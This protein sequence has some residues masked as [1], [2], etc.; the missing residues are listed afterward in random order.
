M[1]NTQRRSK[2]GFTLVELIVVIA[3]IGVLA[4]IIVPTTLHFV[5]EGKTEAAR[6]ELVRVR[7]AINNGMTAAVLDDKTIDVE[8]LKNILTESSITK[9][10]NT[11]TITID[12]PVE[13]APGVTAAAGKITFDSSVNEVEDVTLTI[14]VGIKA[15]DGDFTIGPGGFD[16]D[17]DESGAGN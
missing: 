9:T 17:E 6:E 13:S 2:K 12:K 16:A 4:A 1:K 15:T 3:I 11:I 8:L 10:D 7:D 14:A 5:N